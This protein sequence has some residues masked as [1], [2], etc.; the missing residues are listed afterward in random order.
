MSK[1]LVSVKALIFAFFATFSLFLASSAHAFEDLP[2]V[3]VPIQDW[4]TD[5]IEAP[6]VVPSTEVPTIPELTIPEVTV[7]VDE[8]T[9]IQIDGSETIVV[10]VE[11]ENST[12]NVEDG[13]ADKK[14]ESA[15]RRPVLQAPDITVPEPTKTA[16]S[17]PSESKKDKEKTKVDTTDRPVVQP[18]VPEVVEVPEIEYTSPENPDF[19]SAVIPEEGEIE[20]VEVEKVPDPSPSP[21]WGMLGLG[22]LGAVGSATVLHFVR[23]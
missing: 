15:P 16:E 6:Q 1:I 9:S 10:E 14:T 8:P 19:G 12:E 2:V 13:K 17:K 7:T 20:Q 21:L 4:A 18:Y 23:N 11:E 5:A 22:L 3:E